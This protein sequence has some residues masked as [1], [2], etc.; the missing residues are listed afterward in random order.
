[1]TAIAMTCSYFILFLFSLA[2]LSAFYTVQGH[3][4][5]ATTTETFPTHSCVPVIPSPKGAVLTIKVRL[6]NGGHVQTRIGENSCVGWLNISGENWSQKEADLVCR[7][8]NYSKSASLHRRNNTFTGTYKLQCPDYAT[9]IENCTIKWCLF[10]EAKTQVTVNCINYTTQASTK[11][12]FLSAT[13]TTT[14]VTT[15]SGA[16][17]PINPTT[18]ER[19][20]AGP[21]LFLNEM[22]NEFTRKVRKMRVEDSNM[23]ENFFSTTSIVMESLKRNKGVKANVMKIAEP[24][25][26]F[27][28]RWARHNLKN[29]KIGKMSRKIMGLVFEMNRVATKRRIVFPSDSE[30][31]DMSTTIE[32]P[33]S[34]F[35]GTDR[36][37]VNAL[38]SDMTENIPDVTDNGNITHKII[39]P[40]ISTTL[41]P[42]PE[43]VLEDNV[44]IVLKHLKKPSQYSPKCVFWKVAR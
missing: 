11:D 31:S 19:G 1:M 24:M 10:H 36:C 43:N 16:S 7:K 33:G 22:I 40:V 15:A 30:Q 42:K 8:L 26:K 6:V 13:A 34:L 29:L 20:T 12:S 3:T 25:E 32:L 35:D 28:T 4:T 5:P 27:G 23:L 44:T 2:P 17:K 39:S 41:D 18:K 38:F 9:T 21:K 37:V 14:T